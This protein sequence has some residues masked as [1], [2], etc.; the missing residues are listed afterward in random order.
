M[1]I[2]YPFHI[3][4]HGRTARTDPEGHIRD[5][6]DLFEEYG[7][8]WSYHAFR[9]WAGWSVEHTTDP[10]DWQPSPTPT[11]REKLLKAWFAKNQRPSSR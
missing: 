4:G 10:K 1:Q 2:S 11:N 5:L 9:E 6:I 8:D 3:D 7:W